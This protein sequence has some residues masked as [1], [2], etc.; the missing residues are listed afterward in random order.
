MSTL[1]V[2]VIIALMSL[3]LISVGEMIVRTLKPK[4]KNSEPIDYEPVVTAAGEGLVGTP[5]PTIHTET[6][7]SQIVHFFGHLFHH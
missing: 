5:D 1:F 6:F 2:F 7:F 4:A 3:G